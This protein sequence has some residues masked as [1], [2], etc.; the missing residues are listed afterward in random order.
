MP[1]PGEG[2]VATDTA[3]EGNADVPRASTEVG[4]ADTERSRAGTAESDPCASA[5]ASFQ[6]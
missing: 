3:G 4:G 5:V 2:A 1:F 6:K